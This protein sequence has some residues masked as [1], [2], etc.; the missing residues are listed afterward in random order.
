[1]LLEFILK[2]PLFVKIYLKNAISEFY[3]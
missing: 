1:M 3:S 2:Y